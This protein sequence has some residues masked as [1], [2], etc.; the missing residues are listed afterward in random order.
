[1]NVAIVTLP[2]LNNYGGVLQNY[3]LQIVLKNMGF[4]TETLDFESKTIP[5]WRYVCSW[6]K[7]LFLFF[8]PGKKS[9]FVKMIKKEKRSAHIEEFVSKYIQKTDCLNPSKVRS[10]CVKR[11]GA[12]VVGSDQIWRPKY[13]PSINCSFLDFVKDK[14][15]KRV[16]YAA[17]F[18]V[19]EWEYS[20]SQTK[21]CTS[22]AKRF[23]AISVRE[24]SG[25]I[26]CR[27]YL[28]VHAELVL[29]PTLLLSKTDYQKICENIPPLKKK[30]LVVYVLDMNDSIR[31]L[32]EQIAKEK[33]LTLKIFSA[34]SQVTLSVPEWLAMF[35]DASYV[36]TDSFH[37][38]IFSIIFGKEFKCIYNK[39]RGAARFESLL[40]LYN[41]G[42]L[43]E[44]RQFSLS[45][46]KNALN[47]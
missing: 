16:A 31:D 18:G 21:K 39:T 35:R 6:L 20:V 3:A 28:N 5:L 37:G 9:F 15:V 46:L 8:I 13:S 22:L 43:E 33:N 30:A 45:W 36:V 4:S 47:S 17:S 44:M 29:D 38:T 14:K 7:S 27:E 34:D 32:Y 12:Y 11:Y 41:S 26:L 23:N 10:F 24:K 1:M 19:D 2:L 42:K 40:N 25:L